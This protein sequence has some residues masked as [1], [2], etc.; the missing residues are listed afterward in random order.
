[1]PPT[2]TM[3]RTFTTICGGDSVSSISSASRL[4][5]G[6]SYSDRVNPARGPWKV[7][8]A[9]SSSI[10]MRTLPLPN[11]P[12]PST[13]RRRLTIPACHRSDDTR[14]LRSISDAMDRLRA[15][16]LCGFRETDDP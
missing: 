5:I 7:T 8:H 13:K 6:Y 2:R 14:Y 9:R 10:R 12:M 1:M 3:W 16:G 11:D 4:G 15:P